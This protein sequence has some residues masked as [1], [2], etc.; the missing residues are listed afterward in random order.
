[1]NDAERRDGFY[2]VREPDLRDYRSS[3][4]I[5]EWNPPTECHGA[6]IM[7]GDERCYNSDHFAEIDERRIEMP[8]GPRPSMVG[9]TL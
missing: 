2:R 7:L 5:A 4:T 8:P 9:P 6:W 1:M 3:W